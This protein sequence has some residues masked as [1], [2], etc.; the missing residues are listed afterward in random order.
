LRTRHEGSDVIISVGDNGCG[1]HPAIA[2]R[3]FEP[4]FTTKEVGKGSG[5]GL[6]MVWS[7]V[8]DKHGGDIWF[9]S[10]PGVGSTFFVRLPVSGKMATSSEV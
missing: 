5:Q 10:E 9:D 4:F 2:P 6:A 1:I 7:V 3:V 8:K